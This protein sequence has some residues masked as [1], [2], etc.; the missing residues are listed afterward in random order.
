MVGSLR[1]FPR[2]Y[3]LRLIIEIRNS[4]EMGLGKTIQ[5]IATMAM[6]L[7]AVEEKVRTTLIVMPAALLHQVRSLVYVR[8][9]FAHARLQWKE[10]LESKTNDL[11]TVHIHHTKDKLKTVEALQSKD[12]SDCT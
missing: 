3:S 11:F 9:T 7:P 12:V 10:E 5:M 6:N 8:H 2:L 4:D 1:M